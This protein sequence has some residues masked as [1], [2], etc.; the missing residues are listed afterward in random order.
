MNIKDLMKKSK[1]LVGITYD[2]KDFEAIETKA[3]EVMN[4][5]ATGYGK[6]IIPQN[7]MLDPM[8]DLLPE[9]S[10]LLPLLPGNHWNN[11]PISAKVPVIW[12][13]Q[14]FSGNT[15]WSTWPCG[16]SPVK[17]W[18]DT[19]DVTIVQGQ[20]ILEISLSKRELNYWPAQLEAIIRDRINRSAARTVDAAIINWDTASTGNINGT[21]NSKA[22]Y[23]QIDNWIRKVWIANG[24]KNIG[25]FSAASYLDVVEVLDPGYQA[26]LENLLI[27]ESSNLYLKSLTFDEV[28][29]LDKMW[30]QATILSWVLAKVWNISKLVAR[31]YPAKTD[32]TGVVSTTAGD[33]TK[34]SFAV[35][36]KPAVQYGFGQPLEIDAF[37]CPGKW[38]TLVATMEFWFAIANEVAGLGKTV[39]LGVNVTL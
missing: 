26:D 7:V 27:V 37:K 24:A 14:L 13:A 3:N 23:A 34:G 11:M 1:D 5:E 19:D 15:E 20:L 28:V 2:E 32:A 18:P 9:Y 38:V 36:Y 17:D 10:K 33:N 30:S 31:D 35:I 39:W 4:T 6:E 29:T 21:Y 22:Y 12:E 16:I 25:T 8:L